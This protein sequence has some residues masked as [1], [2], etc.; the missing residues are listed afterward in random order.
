M[1]LVACYV[2]VFPPS[3][4]LPAGP[5]TITGRVNVVDHDVAP[6][7]ITLAVDIVHWTAEGISLVFTTDRDNT[8][9]S[10][11]KMAQEQSALERARIL[12]L[13]LNNQHL[14][15]VHHQASDLSLPRF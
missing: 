15:Q 12:V 6:G 1:T 3:F 10:E 5:T 14:I 7:T 9:T 11:T 13:Q 2:L 4:H 8:D